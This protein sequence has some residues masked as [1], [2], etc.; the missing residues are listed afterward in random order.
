[1]SE[2]KLSKIRWARKLIRE[3]IATQNLSPSQSAEL[4]NYDRRLQEQSAEIEKKMILNQITLSILSQEPS[5][6]AEGMKFGEGAPPNTGQ[7][8]RRTGIRNFLTNPTVQDRMKIEPQDVLKRSFD[9]RSDR[10]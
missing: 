9:P 7:I 8:R 2:E 3:A 1:M 4:Q 6:W 5:I 10:L